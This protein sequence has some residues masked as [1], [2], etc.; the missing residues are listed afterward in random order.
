MS[1]RKQNDRI[2]KAGEK[3]EERKTIRPSQ[4]K[5]I[6]KKKEKERK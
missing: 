4:K 2:Q 5:K 6:V 1:M 3:K